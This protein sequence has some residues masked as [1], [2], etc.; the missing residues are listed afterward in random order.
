[1]VASFNVEATRQA[2]VAKGLLAHALQRQLRKPGAWI[3]KWWAG[4][5][6]GY[7]L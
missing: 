4:Y 7:T 5:G 3:G 2:K 6:Q 1:V